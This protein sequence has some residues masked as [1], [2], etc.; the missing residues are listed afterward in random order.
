MKAHLKALT[1]G[2][3]NFIDSASLYSFYGG[4]LYTTE[5]PSTNIKIT[6]QL[7]FVMFRE[8][9]EEEEDLQLDKEGKKFNDHI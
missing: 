6:T 1:D 8:L 9:L 2:K 3:H 4:N 5:C 7:D